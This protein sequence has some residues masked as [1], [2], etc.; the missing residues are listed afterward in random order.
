MR[1]IKL[2]LEQ[3]KDFPRF[4]RL[5]YELTEVPLAEV[6]LNGIHP[7]DSGSSMTDLAQKFIEILNA[8]E[9]QLPELKEFGYCHDFNYDPERS[10]YGQCSAFERLLADIKNN[11]YFVYDLNYLELLEITKSALTENWNNETVYNILSR[12]YPDFNSIRD[13]LKRKNKNIKLSGY[14]DIK[15]YDLSSILKLS[16]F[17]TEDKVLISE[18]LPVL[19]FRPARFMEKV[20]DSRGLL[21]LTP[22]IDRF[23]IR[24]P[25]TFANYDN[26]GISYNCKREVERIR[27]QPVIDNNPVQRELAKRIA[28]KWRLDQGRYCFT[29]DI[30]TTEKMVAEEQFQIVFPDLT[31]A[32]EHQE[33]HSFANLIEHRLPRFVIGR[34]VKSDSPGEVLKNILRKYNVSMTGRKEEL[35]EKL[36]K[37]SAKAY[38]E[39]VREL[40]DYFARN[41]FIKVDNAA[42]KESKH[43]PVLEGCDIRNMLLAMYAV[44]H[45][46]GNTILESAHC[47]DTFDLISLAKSLI[48]G[49][50]NITGSFVSVIN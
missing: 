29:N 41:R 11:L 1:A 21:R 47:N 14:D 10:Y 27:F 8:K 13:F 6:L 30:Q 25:S 5:A 22:A 33:S 40:D 17:E 42:A 38:R 4:T 16:D 18:A 44:K 3:D 7:W 43:F 39:R 45:L 32:K 28:L 19:N 49:E 20:T 50:V 9:S 37:L 26:P 34:Y 46:R 24:L 36:A 48:N 35:L 31:Y 15:K 23:Q 2:W 12:V